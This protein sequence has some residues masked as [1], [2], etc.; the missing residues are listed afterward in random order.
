M[1]YSMTREAEDQE[2]QAPL[3]P[4][5]PSQVQGHS[6]SIAQGSYCNLEVINS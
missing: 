3:Y 5:L 6:C 1:T 4:F 2:D